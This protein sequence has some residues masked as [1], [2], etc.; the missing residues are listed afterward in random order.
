MCIDKNEYQNINLKFPL[1]L[2]DFPVLSSCFNQFNLTLTLIALKFMKQ[3]FPRTFIGTNF[4]E[5]Q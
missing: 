3:K 5:Q 2:F 4:P 1:Q